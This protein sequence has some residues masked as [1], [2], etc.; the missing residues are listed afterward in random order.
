M[1]TTLP[2]I[3]KWLI[4][5]LMCNLRVKDTSSLAAMPLV[6][7]FRSK[8]TRRP[9]CSRLVIEAKCNICTAGVRTSLISQ[10]TVDQSLGTRRRMKLYCCW[11]PLRQVFVQTTLSTQLTLAKMPI[12]SSWLWRMVAQFNTVTTLICMMPQWPCTWLRTPC[13]F[14]TITMS[15]QDSPSV[16]AQGCK[17]S[18]TVLPHRPSTHTS[19]STTQVTHLAFT[20]PK[21]VTATSS[22]QPCSKTS[23][24]GATQ[25]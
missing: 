1:V 18:H 12:Q 6:M 25:S 2:Q 9:L 13:L 22:Q 19:S 7:L 21:L 10:I 15:S 17:T 8:L 24:S 5:L 23:T 16:T 3:V 11:K 20:L 4:F 14:L